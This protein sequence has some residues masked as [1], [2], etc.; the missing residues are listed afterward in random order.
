M[1]S[2]ASC[3]IAELREKPVGPMSC[4]PEMPGNVPVSVA[5]MGTVT[6]IAGGHCAENNSDR[7]DHLYGSHEPNRYSLM[8]SRLPQI[9]SQSRIVH[10]QLEKATPIIAGWNQRISLRGSPWNSWEHNNRY[11]PHWAP[12]HSCFFF[13]HPNPEE[14]V[15]LL[16]VRKEKLK[17]IMETNEEE[18]FVPWVKWLW[19]FPKICSFFSW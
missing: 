6:E 2:L 4:I 11:F 9:Q 1:L 18:N 13:A 15:S 5:L 19:L 10:S 12:T 17:S 14:T 16:W 8:W 3:P 7:T